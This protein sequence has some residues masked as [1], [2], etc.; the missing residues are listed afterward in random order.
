MAAQRCCRP[1]PIGLGYTEASC[2]DLQPHDAANVI[3]AAVGFRRGDLNLKMT[4]TP[5]RGVT[6]AASLHLDG[7]RVTVRGNFGHFGA[8]MHCSLLSKLFIVFEIIG[9]A[10]LNSGTRIVFRG[11]GEF[12]ERLHDELGFER[13]ALV[14]RDHIDDLRSAF[15]LRL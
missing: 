8:D 2:R 3:R 4:I 1:T 10:P 13:L 6:L 14:L 12:A 5:P 7:E 15:Q 11:H 9:G